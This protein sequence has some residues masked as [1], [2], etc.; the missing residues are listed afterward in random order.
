MC[1]D[2]LKFKVNLV[3]HG[4]DPYHTETSPL[5]LRANKWADFHMIETCIT[6]ELRTPFETKKRKRMLDLDL[7][8]LFRWC[9]KNHPYIA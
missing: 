6:K 2:T 9:S 1:K 5:I 7:N 3:F 4:E 8:F